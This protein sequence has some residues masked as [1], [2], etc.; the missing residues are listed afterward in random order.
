MQKAQ[1]A[2]QNSEQI[3]VTDAKRGKTRATKSQLF[4]VLLLIGWKSGASFVNQSQSLVTQ[5]QNERAI[6]FD[7]IESRP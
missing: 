2:N 1:R 5:N 6:T 3:H 7:T 4:L